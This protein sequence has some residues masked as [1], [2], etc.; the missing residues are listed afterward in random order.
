MELH[1]RSK[2]VRDMTDDGSSSAATASLLASVIPCSVSDTESA[3]E[4]AAIVVPARSTTASVDA[5]E[6]WG[7][8]NT[9]AIKSELSVDDMRH[10]CKA[11][12]T[13]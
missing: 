10:W 7:Q 2:L 13:E 12:I 1:E 5:T 9:H 11:S 3:A 4:R 8:G 6:S